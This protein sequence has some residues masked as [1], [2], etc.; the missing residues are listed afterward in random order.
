MNIEGGS[1][2]IFLLH[3]EKGCIAGWMTKRNN[4]SAP[5][6]NPCKAFNTKEEEKKRLY[7]F[8]LELFKAL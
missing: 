6:P 2:K 3:G 7:F 8:F 5:P 4:D 1:K